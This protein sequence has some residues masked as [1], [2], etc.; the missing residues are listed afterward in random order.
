LG[1][2]DYFLEQLNENPQVK[3][4][5]DAKSDSYRKEYILWIRAAKT[6]ATRQKRIE[7]AMEWIAEGKA[8]FWKYTK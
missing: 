6:D 1:T 7:E 2:P 4:I 3:T 5:F 8:R